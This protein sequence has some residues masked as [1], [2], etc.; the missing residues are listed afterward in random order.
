MSDRESILIT[1]IS[2]RLGRLVARRLHRTHQVI[3]VDRRPFEGRPKDIPMYRL[4]IRRN[5]TEDVFRRHR[6]KAVCHLNV[7][8]DPRKSVGDHHTFNVL[9][10]QRIL[11]WCHR[12]DVPKAVVLSSATTYGPRPENAQFLRE[13]SALLAGQGFSEIR[14]LIE[15]DMFTQG[16]F[17]KHPEI[18][19]VLLR[20]VHILGT[21]RNAASNYLR[22]K[23]VPTMLGFDPMVQII[24]EE[25]VVTA[26]VKALRPGI[27][28]VFNV[29]GPKPVP[30]SALIR[31][32]GKPTVAVPAP[33]FAAA[34]RLMWRYKLT[35]FPAP[36]LDY[37]KYICMADGALAREVLGFKYRHGVGDILDAVLRGRVLR[38]EPTPA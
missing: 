4:D 15:L 10:T 9:G 8:H 35:S 30:L 33:L 16:F 32:A 7:M 23:T 26:I 31:A 17:W 21:V 19:T 27:R 18:E 38:P 24:H 14:D 6:I 34:M 13:D 5:Q 29:T 25:D 11:E 36:E 3:G 12:W 37:L 20:P 22:L 28:G 1:G 2:G